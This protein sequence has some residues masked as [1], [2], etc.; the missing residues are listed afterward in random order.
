MNPANVLTPNPNLTDSESTV[1]VSS[2]ER[3]RLPQRFRGLRVPAVALGVVV[4]S[5][6]CGSSGK[7][8]STGT[9]APAPAARPS[10]APSARPGTTGKISAVNPTNIFIVN[11]QSQSQ[12]TVNFSTSTTFTQTVTST[13]TA[14]KVGDCVTATA[15]STGARPSALPSSRPSRAPVTALTATNVV[16]TATSGSCARSNAA[17]GANPSARPSFRPSARPSGTTRRGGGFGFGNTAFG[18]VASV[19]DGSFVVTSTRGPGAGSSTAKV[20]VTTTSATTYRENEAATRA[21]LKV[22]LC[23]TAIGTT[24]DTGAVNARTI[25]LSTPTSSGCSLGFAG[26]FGRGRFGAAAAGGGG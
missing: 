19:G 13:A 10:G 6:A 22:G 4:L 16:I 26:G 11:D 14:L 5:A 15:A 18:A 7:S 1:N 12:T 17:F 24:D 3:Q 2:F 23:A 20:T 9:T 25:S 21:N 8:V